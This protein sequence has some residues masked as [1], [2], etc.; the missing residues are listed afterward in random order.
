VSI[1]RLIRALAGL[2]HDRLLDE[3]WLLAPTLRIGHQWLE[4]V[5]RTGQPVVNVRIKTLR[6]MA[7]ELAA[8]EMATRKLQLL[9]GRA[10]PMPVDRVFRRLRSKGL[11]YLG[12]LRATAGLAELVHRSIQAIRMACLE[13]HRPVGPLRARTLTHKQL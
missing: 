9:S 4:A 12:P 1:C 6:S 3:K 2:C 5:T 8:P 11:T 13:M 10:G 7:L